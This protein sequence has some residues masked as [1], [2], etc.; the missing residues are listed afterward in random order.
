MRALDAAGITVHG[1]VLREPSLDDVFL[2]L[3]GHRAESGS[4]E[5]PCE[6]QHPGLLDHDERERLRS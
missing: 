4:E 2:Q 5:G 3:T 1:L 6:D